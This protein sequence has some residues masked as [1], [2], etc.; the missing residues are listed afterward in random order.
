MSQRLYNPDNKSKIDNRLAGIHSELAMEV[1]QSNI[2]YNFD[3]TLPLLT[4]HYLLW[5]KYG[6]Q[7]TRTP[8]RCKPN[9]LLY[10]ATGLHVIDWISFGI[11]MLAHRGQRDPDDYMKISPDELWMPKTY[12][13]PEMEDRLDKFLELVSTDSSRFVESFALDR[14]TWNFL[15]FQTQP[16]LGWEDRYLI[17]D[18]RYF[19]DR[20]TE[21]LFMMS[22]NARG[23]IATDSESY[24]HKL[25]EKC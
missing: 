2:F 9:Q 1:L 3:S 4:R 24:G 5:T 12:L 13:T 17:L 15:P 20:V 21:G 11:A 8:T 22:T 14:S 19:L 23:N 10:E 6:D 18:M 16:V 25:T 7:V